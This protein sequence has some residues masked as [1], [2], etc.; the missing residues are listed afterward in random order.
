[1]APGSCS[2]KVSSGMQMESVGQAVSKLATKVN[3]QTNEQMPTEKLW[4]ELCRSIYPAKVKT[5]SMI[6]NNNTKVS[7][8]DYNHN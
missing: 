5:G 1:M 7:Y 6:M 3:K 4:Y 8:N 2:P